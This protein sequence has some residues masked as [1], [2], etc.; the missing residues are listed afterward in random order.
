MR[1]RAPAAARNPEPIAV[2]LAE[3]LPETGLVLEIASGTGE[4]ALH[5]ARAFPNLRWQPSDPDAE[6]RESIEA[7]RLA[8]GPGNLLPPLALD[9]AGAIWPV[10]RA[11]ALLCINMAHISPIAATEG[12]VSAAGRLLPPGGPLVLYGHGLRTRSPPR[13]AISLSTPTSRFVIP[14]GACGGGNGSTIWPRATDW[15]EPGG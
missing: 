9:A 2:V 13:R 1:R 5:F 7:W 3:E 15:S 4:H 10:E 6:A 12:L 8:E 14:R 11:D